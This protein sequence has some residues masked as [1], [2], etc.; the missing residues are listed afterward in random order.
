MHNRRDRWH[1]RAL[2]FF[3][4]FA[5]VPYTTWAVVTE[6]WHLLP[7]HRRRVLLEWLGRGGVHI[8]HVP[9]EEVLGLLA[10]VDRYQDRPMALAD[11]T[12]VW[13][14]EREHLTDIVTL[15]SGFETYRT[16]SDA[17]FVNHLG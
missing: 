3:R 8:R 11:A 1:A 10:L 15:D 14:A 16:P 5:G 17:R 9:Q 4:G 6:S 7:I 13:L 2:Q 12:L